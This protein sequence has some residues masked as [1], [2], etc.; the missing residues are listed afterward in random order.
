MHQ[1]ISVPLAAETLE[2]IENNYS[3][4]TCW[5]KVIT[6]ITQES[7]VSCEKSYHVCKCHLS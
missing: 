4:K 6:E 1:K 5:L 2:V 3:L 7:Q